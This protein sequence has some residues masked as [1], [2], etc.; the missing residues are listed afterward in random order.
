[1]PDLILSDQYALE[2]CISSLSSRYC[3]DKFQ[4]LVFY[5]QA[6][7]HQ[8]L[9]LDSL[10]RISPDVKDLAVIII[11]DDRFNPFLLSC[12]PH[13]R[14]IFVRPPSGLDILSCHKLSRIISEKALL[15]PQITRSFYQETF[16]EYLRSFTNN[17]KDF[18][19]GDSSNGV[20]SYRMQTPSEILI[21]SNVGPSFCLSSNLKS[22]CY[23]ILTNAFNSDIPHPKTCIFSYSRQ[24]I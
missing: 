12:Y 20:I 22:T 6:F 2:S 8:A 13:I 9:V 18:L 16:Y 17:T 1:M 21:Q 11:G 19:I 3:L 7:G 4:L 10:N 23:S 24:N 5:S 14:Y 15:Y